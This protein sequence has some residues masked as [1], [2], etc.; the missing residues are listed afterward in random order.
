MLT[1]SLILSLLGAVLGLLVLSRGLRLVQRVPDL[2]FVDLESNVGMV[3]VAL[4]VSVLSALASGLAPALHALTGDL[5]A[6]MGASV[7][8]SR[9]RGALN[10]AQVCVSC[11]LLLLAVSTARGV[12][13]QLRPD[14]T[15]SPDG[16]VVLRPGDA[17]SRSDTVG[18]GT[19]FAELEEIVDAIPGV[20]AIARVGQFPL[21]G[22]YNLNRATVAFP[23]SDRLQINPVDADY[24]T[25]TKPRLLAGRVFTQS[26]AAGAPRVALVNRA[27]AERFPELPIG[28]SI[29]LGPPPAYQIVGVVDNAP[30]W[31]DP[32]EVEPLAY[33][34]LAQIGAFQSFAR[35]LLIAVA[36]GQERP[37]VSELERRIRLGSPDDVPPVVLPLSEIVA[38]DANDVRVVS[39][40]AFAVG[41]VELLLATV[42][43][44]GVLLFALSART[45]EV[46]V[47]VAL[48]AAPVQAS[49]AVLRGGLFHALIGASVAL[50]LGVPAVKLASLAFPV[51]SAT[52]PVPFLA[53]AAAVLLALGAASL[54]PGW[55]ASRV[56]PAAAL[57]DE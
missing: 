56:Q 51:V 13:T 17:W 54:V 14:P 57:R 44:Y 20:R 43:L 1:E 30:Y 55:R 9:L 3:L 38:A 21:G 42:G 45:R 39:R 11:L 5:R 37:L 27:F 29:E 16:L 32:G 24:F 49:W 46:G 36:P 40:V 23:R 2:G 52:D 53:A 25:V 34:P 31:S 41:G 22:V 50:V 6:G 18:L 47:R 4:G 10:G 35:T 15:F 8:T 28:A 19:R 26:D 33:A 48:G 12:V 7:G